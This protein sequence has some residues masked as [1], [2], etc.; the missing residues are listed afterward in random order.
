MKRS[1]KGLALVLVAMLVPVCAL[2]QVTQPDASPTPDPLVYNDP[3]VHLRVPAGFH[4]AASRSLALTDLTES[5][6]VAAVWVRRKPSPEK[7]S[8]A[9]VANTSRVDG[10]ATTYTDSLRSQQS[11]LLVK[12]DAISL[13]NGMPAYFLT[14]TFGSGLERQTQYAV[15]WSDGQRGAILAL[16]VPSSSGPFDPAQA[17]AMLTDVSAVLYPANQP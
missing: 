1:V 15:V 11:G 6:S 10:W 2:A 13:K 14:L 4:L 12:R 5:P 3:A 9:F 16:A 7:I 8:L 17:K